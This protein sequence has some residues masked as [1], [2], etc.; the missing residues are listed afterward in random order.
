MLTAQA[1]MQYSPDEA[2]VLRDGSLR[3]MHATELVPGDIIQIAVGDRIPADARVL[4]IPSASFTIDQ[5]ILTG[6]STSV[7][8]SVEAV[9]TEKAVKQDMT[10]ML[11]SGTTV[12]SGSAKA[13]VTAIGTRTAIGSIHTSITSQIAEKTPL[14]Q[15]LDD[16]GDSLAKVITVCVRSLAAPA[17]H[18][19]SASSSG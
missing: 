10:N 13:V 9:K 19:A 5:A 12:V 8:K 17:D 11:F 6:E 14:K 18:A 7:S 3:K 16:F 2:K 4:S 1:L 15:K